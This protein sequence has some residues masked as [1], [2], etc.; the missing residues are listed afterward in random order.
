MI[1]KY[2]AGDRSLRPFSHLC[3]R[4]R[5][6]GTDDFEL[7]TGTL[8]QDG[9]RWTIWNGENGKGKTLFVLY[10]DRKGLVLKKA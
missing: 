8:D 5:E 7:A 6:S 4:L 10:R 9:I 2:Y 1:E 3:Y